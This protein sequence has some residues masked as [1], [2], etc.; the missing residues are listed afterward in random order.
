MNDTRRAVLVAIADGPVA[1]PALADEL[2]ISR[3]AVWNHVDALR[4]AGFEVESGDDGYR[5]VSVPEFG[6]LAV[7]F[8]L[9]APFEV[10]Y[11]ESIASTND[12]AREL[13]A[14][15]RADVAVLTDR[16]TGGRGRLD[17][18]WASP[19]GGV[20]LSLVLRPDLPASELPLVTLAAA[21]ATTRGAREA[22]VNAR[23]K[24][25][26]DVLV[27][28]EG[29]ELK[30]AGILTELEGDG[31]DQRVVVG[32]GVNAN[33]DPA[34]L[35]DG[36]TSIREQVGDVTRRV[37]VQRLLEEFD[38]LRGRPEAILDSWREYAGTLGREVRVETPAGTV[39]GEAVRIEHPGSL[40]VETED[41]AVVVD[42]GDCEHLR[43]VDGEI[44]ES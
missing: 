25:P 16:Q 14:E 8:G 13:A 6:G 29:G 15:G 5:L 43:P 18:E 23:I 27:P 3:A 21:V 35:P 12:R 9:D 1:G 32:I 41:G 19:P 7:Q 4:Q 37:F 26:N 10:E 24:W 42:A 2:E 36:G 44:G 39:I 22:G 40:V 20:W 17:R 33:V 38:E 34:D 30:L 28:A 11:H 31:D